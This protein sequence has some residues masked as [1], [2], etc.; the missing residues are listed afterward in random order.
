MCV[1]LL[2][3]SALNHENLVQLKAVYMSRTHIC[4]LM[5]LAGGGELYR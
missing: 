4:L 5:E 2:L 3:Q 1:L